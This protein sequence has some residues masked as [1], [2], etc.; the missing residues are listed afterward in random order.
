MSSRICYVY[1]SLLLLLRDWPLIMGRGATKQEGGGHVKL[2]PYKKGWGGG[3]GRAQ[4][5]LVMLKGGGV[6]QVL[7]F[8]HIEGV[9]K[10]V[11]TL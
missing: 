6:Q 8:S 9:A 3:G 4:Q 7:S 10:N 1:E 5:V 2:Y 11:S